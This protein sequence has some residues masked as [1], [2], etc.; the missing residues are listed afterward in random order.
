[1]IMSIRLCLSYNLLNAI[2]SPSKFVCF[3]ESVH[4]CHE[5]CHDVT[6]SRRKWHAMC[7]HNIIYDMASGMQCV[8]ITSFMTW[9]YSLNN[10]NVI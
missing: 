10:I 5:H 9:R 8:V 1:M 7:G 2:L 4:C 3:N 6:C